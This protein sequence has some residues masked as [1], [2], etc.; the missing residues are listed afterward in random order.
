MV[1]D[2]TIRMSPGLAV[3]ELELQCLAL[4]AQP[5]L[6]VPGRLLALGILLALV[7]CGPG[8]TPERRDDAD[9]SRVDSAGVLLSITRRDVA[10]ASLGWTVDSEPDL[11]L[12]RGDSP[13]EYFHRVQGMKGSADG[14]V[15]VVDGGSQELRFYDFEGRLVKRAGG[16]GE[17]PGEFRDPVLVP[18]AGTDSLLVFDKRLPWA[19]VLSP[20]G[21]YGRSTRHLHGPPYG[22]RA[23]V[24][25][26][27]YRHMLFNASGTAGGPEAPRPTQGMLQLSQSFLWY[28]AATGSRLTVDSVL[29]DSRYF[30]RGLD[31]VAP[32]TPRSSAATAA[33]AAFI[34]RGSPA[35]VLE[36]DVEGEL[37]RVFRI[38]GFG[39]PVTQ[40]MIDAFIDLEHSR[41]PVRYG[42]L[43]RRSWYRIYES[44][45]LPDT[46]PAFQ[47]LQLDELGWLWAEVY[48]FDPAQ[49]REWVVFDEEGRAHGTV[50]TPP[51][52]EVEWIGRD[53]ILGVWKDEFDVEYVHRY[54]L[55]RRAGASGADSEG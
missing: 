53:A 15:V 7:A 2:R 6:Q 38:E 29:V 4:P 23:P 14:G 12:G 17:G 48:D 46:L 27:G 19:Q 45:G 26:V 51:G 28:D 31:W 16:R 3:C 43:N 36:Y 8:S 13:G 41:R 39:R 10:H 44:I 42:P 49:P 55:D 50:R 52:L 9:F 33:G 20:E 34:A 30:D 32:F 35:E 11:R 24:G 40:A 18:M 37:L 1:A 5:R 47:A 21:E 25:A 22:G 54:P